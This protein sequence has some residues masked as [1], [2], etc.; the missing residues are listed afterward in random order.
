MFSVLFCFIR[1]QAGFRFTSFELLVILPPPLKWW[2]YRCMIQ[3]LASLRV[4]WGLVLTLP[5]VLSSIPSDH[6][7]AHNHL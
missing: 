6:M 1:S 5:E 2:A 7:V 4:V 3:E